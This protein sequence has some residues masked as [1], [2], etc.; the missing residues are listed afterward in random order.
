MDRKKLEKTAWAPYED[1]QSPTQEDWKKSYDALTELAE[2][3]PKDGRYPNTL[4]YLC[5]YGRHTGKRDYDEA[6]QWFEKGADL[7][8][9]ES[10]YK[11]AD[12]LT[13]GLGGPKDPDRAFRMYM[14]MYVY[15]RGEFEEGRMDSKFADTA[16]RMGHVFHDGKI[17]ERNDLEAL[18]YLLEA[19][20]AMDWRKQY[21]EFGDDTVEKNIQKM[22]DECEKPDE[23]IQKQEQYGIRLRFVA[24]RLMP[25]EPDEMTIDIEVDRNG[26]ARLE[27]HRKRKDGMKPRRI[28]WSVPPAMKCF[29]TDSVVLYGADIREIWNRS[30]GE[31]II[32]DGF[33]H[34]TE[35]DTYLFFQGDELQCKLQGGRYVLP[36]DEFWK[37]DMKKAE[38]NGSGIMQ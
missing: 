11:L 7:K 32:C 5:Y 16:L 25:F 37:T 35:T 26:V 24:E 36:M 2:K 3:Y 4:G 22:I 30:P 15:C 6:R 8:M 29:M 23:E 31:T 28:L 20:Y 12:M 34:D 18:G 14:H 13:D 38:D 10:T 19:R 33:T 17:I 27:F 21:N 1:I 9:I